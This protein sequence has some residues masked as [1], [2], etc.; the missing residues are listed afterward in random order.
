L[1]DEI[2]SLEG[3]QEQITSLMS[4]PDYHRLGGEQA[5]VDRRRLEELEELLLLKFARWQALEE[6]RT[7]P[8]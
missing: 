3:E 5:R 6:R 2:E 1:P 7:N 4:T 8:A